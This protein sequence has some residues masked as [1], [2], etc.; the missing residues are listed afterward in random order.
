MVMND[1]KNNGLN[2][3]RRYRIYLMA[4][5]FI[6]LFFLR[7]VSVLADDDGGGAV[8]QG[9]VTAFDIIQLIVS[10]IS[11]VIALILARDLKGSKLEN[12]WKIIVI[13]FIIYTAKEFIEVLV[14]LGGMTAL[15]GFGEILEL[16]LLLTFLCALLFIYK[17]YRE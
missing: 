13:G 7:I 12:G 8:P 6:L 14:E 5:T 17:A 1:K 15:E 9:L 16:I 2:L 11:A 4:F 3:T 10:V